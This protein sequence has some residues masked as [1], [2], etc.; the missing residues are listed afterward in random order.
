MATLSSPGIGSGLD[1]K[2]IVNQLVELE[3]R[4][5]AS[6]QL[7]AAA[8]QTRLSVVGQIKST[9]AAL[10][11]A[12]GQLQLE[13]TYTAMRVNSSSTAVSGT[14]AFTAISG[15]YSVQVTQLARGQ[16]VQSSA[17][18]G[19]VGSGS[20]TIQM[21]EWLSGP[22]FSAGP[23]AAVTVSIGAG[24]TLVDVA[25]KI[26]NATSGI[27]ASVINDGS[28]Q[29]LV[30]RSVDTGVTQGF[31]VQVSDDDGND[32][33]NAGLSRLAYDPEGGPFGLTLAQSAQNTLATVDSVAVSSANRTLAD[34]IPG[35]TLQ[36]KEITSQP[37]TVEVGRDSSV[38]RKA[39]EAFVEAYNQVNQALNEALRYDP[40]T[41][42]AGPLQGDSTI[43]TLQSALRR[44]LSGTGPGPLNMQRWSDIGVQMNRDGSLTIQSNKLDAAAQ[45]PGAL[46]T[47][48]ASS[49]SGQLGLAR[50]LRNFV[51]GA[52]GDQGR[53]HLKT[54]AVE[55]E[56][57][58]LD[59][60][61]QRIKDRASRA[62]QRLLAQYSRLDASVS[63][64]TALNNYVT[65]QV[66]Q[67]NKKTS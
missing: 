19:A 37:V 64:L 21:G 29:R 28:G 36:V 63:Q 5:L 7:R 39:V 40:Q 4:P 58:R 3:K 54:R 57:R 60:Q 47:L 50:Q 61:A 26:N 55:A 44:L 22:S 49:D 8:A 41:K 46:K 20:L 9:L 14:A 1:I 38:V 31:R 33:D 48:L 51:T 6:I 11:D 27:K 59:E 16:V 45:Q 24:D 34:A 56:L 17:L 18:S 13:G 67:W 53:V 35:V 43:V 25:A 52:V 30:L 65:Q 10:D 32:T 23:A 66:A 2:S 42:Q 12:L 15:S 62:E